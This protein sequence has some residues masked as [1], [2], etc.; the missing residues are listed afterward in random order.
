MRAFLESIQSEKNINGK[1]LAKILGCSGTLLTQVKNNQRKLSYD[2]IKALCNLCNNDQKIEC[3]DAWVNSIDT[4]Y[5]EEL[6]LKDTDIQEIKALIK[7]KICKNIN[8]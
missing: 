3:I 2:C 5:L 7:E 1:E 6:N 8:N 4:I